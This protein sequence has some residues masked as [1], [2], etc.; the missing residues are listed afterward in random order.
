MEKDIEIHEKEPE[1][2]SPQVQVAACYLE[3]EGK[4]LLLQR[5]TNKSEAGKWGVPAGKLE[6]NELPIDAATRELFEETGVSIASSQIH[7]LG[8]LYIRKPEISYIY[9][10][11]KVHIDH[12]P[13]V[14]LSSEH[15]SYTWASF[16][17]LIKMPLMAGAK[18]AVD[19]YRTFEVNG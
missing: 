2:F 8:S 11:F 14:C 5:A 15:Q 7:S 18:Q 16:E 3:K 1:G 6:K 9:H 19:F 13:P 17:E 10:L 12:L 4:V